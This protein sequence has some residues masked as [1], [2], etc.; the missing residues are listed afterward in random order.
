VLLKKLMSLSQRRRGMTDVKLTKGLGLTEVVS[1]CLRTL[2]LLISE[3]QQLQ[4][5]LSMLVR[6]LACLLW[7]DSE[8]EEEVFNWPDFG[9][10]FLEM[11]FR[12]IHLATCIVGQWRWWFRWLACSFRGSS[13]LFSFVYQISN[14][15]FYIL[16]SLFLTRIDCFTTLLILT[17]CYRKHSVKLLRL[18]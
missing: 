4:K 12:D 10:S 3:Q 6:W 17:L 2:I 15:N 1:R 16:V 5:E 7:G 9:A 14:C 8:R 18:N 13:S 11:I